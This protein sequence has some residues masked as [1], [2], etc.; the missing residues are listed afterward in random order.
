MLCQHFNSHAMNMFVE[1]LIE[2]TKEKCK[3]QHL[4]RVNTAIRVLLSV[5]VSTRLLYQ[6]YVQAS[7]IYTRNN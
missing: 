3:L 7:Y 5:C 1:K 6:Y 2:N 4:L